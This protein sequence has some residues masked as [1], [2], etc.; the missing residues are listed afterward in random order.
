MI[1]PKV[2]PTLGIIKYIYQTHSD[3]RSQIRVIY[4]SDFHIGVIPTN[5]IPLIIHRTENHVTKIRYDVVGVRTGRID[6]LT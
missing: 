3:T 1:R 6:K 2:V 4:R 5:E